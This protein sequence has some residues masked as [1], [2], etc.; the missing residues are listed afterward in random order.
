MAKI[1]QIQNR[2]EN[3]SFGVL[4]DS[5][6]NSF[7]I[8]AVLR[9]VGAFG[10][11]FIA[12]SEKRF[13]DKGD[14]K[15]LDTE[16]AH[17]RMPCFLG[18]NDLIPFIPEK[19]VPVA[20]ELSDDA[21]SLYDFEHPAQAVYMFGPEDGALKDVYLN[22]CVHKIYIPTKYS[23]NLA[24]TVNIV[25]YDRSMKMSK[26]VEENIIRCPNCGH[27][28]YKCVDDLYTCNACNHM[29]RIES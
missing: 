19:H 26:R 13:H 24:Q 21:T 25:A 1:R 16:A 17:L 9:T 3:I 22:K 14:W 5:P 10:G 29:W 20:I 27:N 6:K 18:V 7:N 8:G 4:L 28:Y 23:L 12:A 2:L 15:T 11:N